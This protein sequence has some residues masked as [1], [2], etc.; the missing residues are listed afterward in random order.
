MPSRPTRVAAVLALA[1]ITLM[2]IAGAGS[3]SLTGRWRDQS[4]AALLYEF[5]DDGSV[6]LVRDGWDVPVFRYAVEG[7]VVTFHDGMGRPRAYRFVLDGDRLVLRELA[8]NG[9]AAEYRRE[10]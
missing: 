7:D 9:D 5:R 4:P 10:R 8:E 6:W 3:V 2:V 1:F